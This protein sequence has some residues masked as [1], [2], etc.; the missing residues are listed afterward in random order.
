MYRYTCP[1]CRNTIEVK[2]RIDAHFRPFCT[3]RCKLI[4]LGRWF[5]E[6]YRV[7]DPL[8]GSDEDSNPAGNGS[9]EFD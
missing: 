9:S 2:Q 8:Q 5:N 6:E 3:E 1:T 7:S 4:D